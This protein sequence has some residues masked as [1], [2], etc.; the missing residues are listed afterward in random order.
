MRPLGEGGAGAFPLS[1]ARGY[2]Y[3]PTALPG[4]FRRAT[5][6]AS[7]PDPR[8][9]R[10]SAQPPAPPPEG[11]AGLQVNRK[12]P[13]GPSSARAVLCVRSGAAKKRMASSARKW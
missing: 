8:P 3:A 2:P 10:R 6:L 12:K 9:A 13:P 11:V 5:S 7:P 1:V 4:T